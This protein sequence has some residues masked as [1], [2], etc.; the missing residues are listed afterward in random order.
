MYVYINENNFQGIY[1][2]RCDN[3]IKIITQKGNFFFLYKNNNQQ[4]TFAFQIITK[5]KLF[6]FFCLVMREK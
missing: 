6:L 2:R 5:K 3:D 4:R 1:T